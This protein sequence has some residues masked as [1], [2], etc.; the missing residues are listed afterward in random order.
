MD[1][2]QRVRIFIVL[3]VGI[4][5]VVA[6]PGSAS[7]AESPDITPTVQAGT[8][9]PSTKVAPDVVAAVASGGKLEVTISLTGLPKSG[10][11]GVSNQDLSSSIADVQSRV[12]GAVGSGL[13][14]RHQYQ[15]IPA[16]TAEV[17]DAALT[18]LAAHP[19][20]IAVTGPIEVHASL[21]Q[22]IP[23]IRADE[24]RAG[25]YTG[26]GVTV[27][28]MD[29]GI[30][31]DHPAL[32]DDLAFQ[33]CF[34]ASGCPGGGTSGFSAE[35]GNSH[36][37]HVSGMIT[38]NGAVGSI[39]I[40]PD[41]QIGAYKILGDSGSGTF[42]DVL[43]ALD[44]VI[45]NHPEVDLIN[46]SFGDRDPHPP[47]TC[48]SIMPAFTTAVDTLRGMNITTFAAS[49]NGG[50]K[51]GLGFPACITN[52]V[53]VGAVYDDNVG[54]QSW[55]VCSDPVT[56]A[57]QVTCFS[58]SDSSLDL[59]A[60]GS[61]IDSTVPGGGTAVYSGTSM[62]SP[63]AVGVAALLLDAAG[64]LAPSELE[65]RLRATGTPITDPGNGI[66][67]CR[68]DAMNAILNPGETPCATSLAGP[69]N[70]D[71]IAARPLTVGS[72]HTQFTTGATTEPGEAE[73][74]GLIGAT[75]WF[76]VNV[77]VTGDL[78]IH[79]TGSTF[80]TVL[81]AYLEAP[82]PPGG[83]GPMLACNDD[84]GSLQSS[85]SVTVEAGQRIL[86]QAGGFNGATGELHISIRP[87]NNKIDRP[88][89]FLPP[90]SYFQGTG[91]ADT[92]PG[93]PAPCGGIGA[94]V[95]FV[96]NATASSEIVLHTV[97]ST[98][99]TVLAV[100]DGSGALPGNLITCN[101][102]FNGLQSRVEFLVSPGGTYYVQAGGF[103]GQSGSLA[104]S[105]TQGNDNLAEATQL[106]PL[107][108]PTI[109]AQATF[110]ASLEPF[111]QRPCGAIGST[112]WYSFTAGLSGLVTANTLRSDFDTVLA[113][114]DTT[115]TSPAGGIGNTLACNDDAG[116]TYGLRS[117]ITFFVSQGETYLIQAGGYNLQA[118]DLRLNIAMDSVLTD[119]D[120]CADLREI[121]PDRTH[122]GDRN[123]LD[124]WDFYDVSGDGLIDLTDA[125]IILTH[126]GEL[127]GDPGYNP[128]LDRDLPDITRPHSPGPPIVPGIDLTDALVNLLSFGDDCVRPIP[129][130]AA[131]PPPKTP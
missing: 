102:D 109:F 55:G 120:T 113:A 110:G 2:G 12:I 67:F 42:S 114:Y 97:G 106:L 121:G 100:Y 93:E 48:Q 60:P 46:M 81:A 22:A 82:S 108:Y 29:T 118:G 5:A 63:A 80:D 19:D 117:V 74:C 96:I 53:S 77:P 18:A 43:L 124:P 76:S 47:G 116:G 98:F 99:D 16:I 66:Q 8:E 30:D 21:E 129:V 123:P 33:R 20:V 58:Q 75:V 103:G 112:V 126:F 65:A 69:A 79:T 92:D 72:P 68:V 84:A 32:S 51:S 26:D 44:D 71:L 11:A 125:L 25:G 62:A 4:T 3:L 34:L 91:D 39:G 115:T 31:T 52:I 95:W 6:E 36:G 64:T 17:D 70:D 56:A 38:S 61:R 40:A 104:L 88:Q 14:V 27:A 45:A 23:L 37:T 89:P 85:V 54:Y 122:G 86:L 83:L 15:Y 105:L 35:D 9:T 107:P 7:R 28:V 50:Y 128:A 1:A 73:P 87:P 10:T 57:D 94:T 13:I 111:E 59:L 41:A 49:G 127:P 101:D 131:I 78:V 119:A 24:A 130:G 90:Y